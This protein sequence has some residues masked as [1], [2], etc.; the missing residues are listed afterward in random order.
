[1]RSAPELR[2][3]AIAPGM[4]VE[5]GFRPSSV[6]VPYG[7]DM[8]T[9]R[10]P[11]PIAYSPEGELLAVG[12]EDGGVLV[13]AAD[14]GRALR[15]LQGHEGRV[16][17]VK[18]GTD[19]IATGGSDGT[20]RLWDPVSGKCRHR[21][22][23]HPDGVWPVVLDG[24]GTLLATGDREGLVTVWDVAT[25][26]PVHRLPGHTAPVYTV[27]FSPDG[28]TLLTGD[29]AAGVRLWDLGTGH[30]TAEL[31]GHR[32]PLYRARFSP[33]GT[34]F[35]TADRGREG[36]ETQG[37]QEGRG[38]TV[39][40]WRTAGTRLLH[41]FTGHTGR[42]Y[43]LDFHP[44]GTLLAS[45]D[46]D[47]QVRLWDPV[48]GT[49]AGT[50]E[51]C[52][53]AVYQVLFGGEDGNLLAACDSDGAVRMWT[54]TARRHGHEVVLHEAAARRTPRIRVG[55]CLPAARQPAAHRGQRRRRADLG[56]RHRTGQAHPA[57]PRAPDLLPGLL[58]DGAHLATCGNDGVVRLWDTRTGRRTEELTGRGDRLVSVAFSP[59]EPVLGTASN[60]GDI[61]LWNPAAG[62]Y[63]REYDVE[64]EHIWAE[65]FSGDGELL[66]TANDDDSVRLW[67]R[68][69]GAHLATL[70]Q[71][72][73]RVRS[74]AFA[75]DSGFLA[76]GCDDSFVR[77]WEARTGR[78]VEELG[79][80]EDRV[81]G[82]AFGPGGAWLASA[83]WDGTAVVWRGGAPSL[84][85]TGRGGRLWTLAAH[86][87][88]PL[89][90]T[91]GDDRSI[92][93]WNAETGELT[94]ELTGHTGRVLSV[95][96]SPDGSSLASGGEDGTVRIWNLPADGAPALRAT[97]IGVPGG[98]AALTPAG[99]YKYEGDV[100]GEFWHVVG[101]A[102]FS[103]GEL[104][105]YLPGVHQLALGEEL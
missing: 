104:D 1:M 74:I 50:L 3:A 85:L 34:V 54:V 4:P 16:Y 95:A 9:S 28:R 20:V 26:E 69:T 66:A 53:G 21:L 64:T 60:D 96:F 91:A 92:G 14:S 52:T 55:L 36:L 37:E 35:A 33:D 94:A 19:T 8:R 75:A 76:T 30:C 78:L 48:V 38:G 99:G 65:A 31:G 42:V 6:G 47:G 57:R 93:L 87:V 43:T 83:G 5:A 100:A 68:S 45:G 61:Y 105:A 63:L 101:M 71:H 23:V 59:A 46:T 62:E 84:R 22:E 25:G 102:R 10:L 56:G 103:P 86:P 29:A 72:R 67:Y 88:L 81:Y 70:D 58:S 13:C 97:L 82:V 80:H 12:S 39:R 2:T 24:G 41:E 73:G 77:L 51:R 40:I 89:L 18:F 90:A 27:A 44:D 11:E 79:A 7:F 32:E 98:W 49:P 15:T 17:A